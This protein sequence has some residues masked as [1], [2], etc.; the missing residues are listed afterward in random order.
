M[1][2]IADKC[3]CT[4]LSDS[5]GNVRWVH[6]TSGVGGAAFLVDNK[7]RGFMNSYACKLI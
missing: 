4:L 7:G 6:E 2:Q 3:L 1:Y 5:A